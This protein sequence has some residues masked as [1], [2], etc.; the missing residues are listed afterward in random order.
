M[1]LSCQP[2]QFVEALMTFYEDF[3]GRARF[4]RITPPSG[5]NPR[6][7]EDLGAA[8]HVRQ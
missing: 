6:G 4:H 2:R 1:R 5:R 8:T 3:N 7:V